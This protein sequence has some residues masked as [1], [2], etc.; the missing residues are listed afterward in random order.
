VDSRRARAT[1][2]SPVLGEGEREEEGQRER[3]REQT[4]TVFLKRI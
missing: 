2:R 3:E 4:D 1:Q